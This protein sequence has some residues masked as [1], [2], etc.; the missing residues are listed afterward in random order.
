MGKLR[1]CP[2]CG[3]E[4]F[5]DGTYCGLCGAKL[6]GGK[7]SKSSKHTSTPKKAKAPKGWANNWSF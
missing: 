7:S 5:Y 4:N 6:S 1:K 3:H 2:K